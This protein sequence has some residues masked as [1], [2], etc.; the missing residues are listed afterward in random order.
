MDLGIRGRTALVAAG[1]KGL[2]KAVARAFTA[3]GVNVAL[4]ARDPVTAA[5]A[6]R[7]IADVAGDATVIGLAADVTDPDQVR[8][9]VDIVIERFGGADILFTNAPGPPPARF[10]ELDDRD[11]NRAFETNLMSAVRLARLCLPGMRERRWG[12]IISSTSSG[13]KQ[14]LA[15]LMLSN[16]IRGATVAWAKCLADEVAADGITVNTLAP[17]SV[18]TDNLRMVVAATAER[19][20]I[21]VEEVHRRNVAAIPVG[22]YGTPGEIAAMATFLASEQAAFVTGVTL[23]VDGGRYRGVS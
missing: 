20:G 16:S 4:F 13:V 1:S 21:D 7:E 9:V 18:D 6:A 11:W 19:L 15:G 17:G 5:A 10:D 3:E 22:R 23:L 8:E 14:P 12:R 2:G